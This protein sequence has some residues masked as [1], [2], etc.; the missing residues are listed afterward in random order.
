MEE[1]VAPV[2][3]KR[4]RPSKASTASR[5]VLPP[6]RISQKEHVTDTGLTAQEEAFCR[7][8]SMGMGYQE[9]ID[10]SNAGISVKTA[11]TWENK[12]H[13]KARINM[14]V[15]I[16]SRSAIL[17]TGLDREWVIQNLMTVTNRC[18]QAEPVLNKDG[19]P[20]GEYRFDSGGATRSLHL[21]GMELGMFKQQEAKPGDEYANL[22]D[23]DIA[24]I[25]IELAAQIGFTAIAQGAEEAPGSERTIDV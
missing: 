22:S 16:A 5:P 25:T 14:L 10:A 18:M 20:T 19:E 3:R 9:A 17:K 2:K 24:R 4:G 21:L 6:L 12:A 1:V 23:D 8:R 7:A 15:S 13:I 11:H